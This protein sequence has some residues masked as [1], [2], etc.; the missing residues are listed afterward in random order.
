MKQLQRAT[1][2][3]KN[4]RHVKKLF[5]KGF[6]LWFFTE[7]HCTLMSSISIEQDTFK[8]EFL[9]RQYYIF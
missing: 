5:K 6:E 4:I 3:K 7:E 8:N 1:K 9:E 2:I